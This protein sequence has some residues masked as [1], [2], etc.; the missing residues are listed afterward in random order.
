MASR[1]EQKEALRRER[2]EREQREAQAAA[3]KRLIGIVVGAI[4]ALGIVVALAVVVFAGDDGGGGDGGGGSEASASTSYPDGGE[5]PEQREANLE[6]AIA[7][8]GCKAETQ[9]APEAAGDHVDRTVDYETEPPALGPHSGVH[10]DDGAFEDAPQTE[11]LV[12]SLEHGRIIVWVKPDAP[13]ALRSQVKAFFDE[14]PYHVMLVP[15]PQLRVPIALSAWV[16]QDT[17]RILRCAEPNDSM[18]DALRAFKEQY[19]DKAPE[20]VP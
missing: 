6:K 16:G 8:S 14:D 7:A 5:L 1:K 18:W 19:R 4:L 11:R 17:G 20:F 12:H 15:R 13:E 3:R 9:Q 2:M 10:E